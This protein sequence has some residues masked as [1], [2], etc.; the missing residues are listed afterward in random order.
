MKRKLGNGRISINGIDMGEA[1]DISV[2]FD[3]DT[4]PREPNAD[5]DQLSYTIIE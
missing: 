2:E 3:D 4:H 1:T 5:S